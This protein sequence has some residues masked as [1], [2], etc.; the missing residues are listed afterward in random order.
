MGHALTEWKILC[1]ILEQNADSTKAQ[2]MSDYMR[3]L[4]PF[5]GIK[6]PERKALVRG[7]DIKLPD[8]AT[9]RDLVE[10]CFHAG[11]RETHYA[12]LDILEIHSRLWTPEVLD[13]LEELVTVHSWWDTVDRI[14]SPLLWRALEKFPEEKERP[15]LWIASPNFWLQ[16]TALLYQRTAKLRTDTARLAR[17][18]EQTQESSEFFLRKAIGWALRQYGYTDP[19]WVRQFVQ[20]HPLPRTCR[21][22]RHYGPCNSS[23]PHPRPHWALPVFRGQF[24]LRS[25]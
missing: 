15:D 5:L 6:T 2:A 20:D 10:L 8:F 19:D 22:A 14:S 4:F 16:R 1:S 18:I 23:G 17:Y 13:L 24:C 11:P 7:C 25:R 12:G 3:N 9:L 21:T